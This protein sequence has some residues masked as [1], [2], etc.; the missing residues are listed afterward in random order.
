[1][2]ILLSSWVNSL[3]GGYQAP[4]G[5]KVKVGSPCTWA[6]SSVCPELKGKDWGFFFFFL[7]TVSE[8]WWLQKM[9]AL[10]LLLQERMA[11][12]YGKDHSEDGLDRMPCLWPD[13]W[14]RERD[15]HRQRENPLSRVTE[16]FHPTSHPRSVRSYSSASL[17]WTGCSSDWFPVNQQ[18]LSVQTPVHYPGLLSHPSPSTDPTVVWM[19]LHFPHAMDCESLKGRPPRHPPPSPASTLCLQHPAQ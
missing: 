18:A 10:C 8:T 14:D 1:M 6:H 17:R 9:T 16:S 12:G 5:Y 7:K 2:E 4:K 19:P 11:T 15:R 3:Q 13:A